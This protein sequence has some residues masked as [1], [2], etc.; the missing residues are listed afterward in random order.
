MRADHLH[1]DRREGDR[2]AELVVGVAHDE[3]GEAGDPGTFSSAREARRDADEVRLGDAGVEEALGEL[4]GEEIGARRV[5]HVAVDDH[6]VGVLFADLGQRQTERLADGFAEFHRML[7]VFPPSP[8]AG[9]G[10]GVRG[11]DRNQ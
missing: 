7:P 3:G 6:D 10:P 8:L 2:H 4:L 5:V 11:R 1:V 9:E